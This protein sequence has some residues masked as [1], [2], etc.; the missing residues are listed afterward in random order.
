MSST[1]DT[2]AA[3]ATGPRPTLRQEDPRGGIQTGLREAVRKTLAKSQRAS[4]GPQ[5]HTLIPN[6]QGDG[7]KVMRVEPLEGT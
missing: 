6:S 3:L 5:V 2:R 1:H 7:D 4:F